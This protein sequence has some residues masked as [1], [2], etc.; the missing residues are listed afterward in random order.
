MLFADL[1]L[2]IVDKKVGGQLQFF[3][4]SKNIKFLVA[5]LPSNRIDP[6]HTML[7]YVRQEFDNFVIRRSMS[8][9]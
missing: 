7:F 6:G 4:P 3:N 1:G 8:P 2:L 5:C 9:G